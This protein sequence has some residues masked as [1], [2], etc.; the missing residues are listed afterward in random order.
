[1]VL[2]SLEMMHNGD[3]AVTKANVGQELEMFTCG[4]IHLGR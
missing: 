4:I 1:M 3:A 2:Y